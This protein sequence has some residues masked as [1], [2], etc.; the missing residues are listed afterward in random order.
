MKKVSDDLQEALSYAKR[1]LKFRARSKRELEERLLHRGF[2]DQTVQNAIENLERSGLIDDEK[3]AYLFAYD[4]LTVQG[5]GPFRIKAKL[6]QLGIS[7]TV[8]ENVLDK[9]MKEVDLAFLLRKIVRLHKV[10]NE[11]IQEFLYRRGF[12][13]EYLQTF[14]IEG[15]AIK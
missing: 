11:K 5:F 8:I 13:T 9:V 3:F 4:M 15:G 12:S 14:D 2:S 1:L 7:Q 6:K 10:E